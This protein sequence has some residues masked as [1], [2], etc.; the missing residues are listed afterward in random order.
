MRL[1][2]FTHR[3]LVFGRRRWSPMQASCKPNSDSTSRKSKSSAL[4]EATGRL[5]GPKLRVPTNALMKLA[6]KWSHICDHSHK[7]VNVGNMVSIRCSI[8]RNAILG[9]LSHDTGIVSDV[10]LTASSYGV[11]SKKPVS[12]FLVVLF[13]T[14]DIC[15]LE[16]S[17][18]D[19]T[20]WAINVLSDNS[21]HSG[22]NFFLVLTVPKLLFRGSNLL[23][24][25]LHCRIHPQIYVDLL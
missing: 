4:I 25:H 7:A 1:G 16:A 3:L 12:S 23:I 21:E 11:P 24:V 5:L 2:K 18:S 17:E 19:S 13:R 15:L 14:Y 6:K 20:G 8:N 10:I 22:G 9:E